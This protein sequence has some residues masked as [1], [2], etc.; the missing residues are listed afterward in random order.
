MVLSELPFCDL[1]DGGYRVTPN[2]DAICADVGNE[3]LA[4]RT[5]PGFVQVRSLH[6]RPDSQSGA[7]LTRHFC[8]SARPEDKHILGSLPAG[9]ST[10][11][12]SRWA[13]DI[14]LDGDKPSLDEASCCRVL[15]M[16]G[17]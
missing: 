16:K 15:V 8:P 6:D 4:C 17:G 13:S 2:L 9:S 1:P 3:A 10:P 5:Q 7:P 11:S 12:Y 14:V